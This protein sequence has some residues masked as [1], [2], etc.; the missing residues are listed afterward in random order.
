MG[1]LI[2]EYPGGVKFNVDHYK[3]VSEARGV[4]RV[5]SD[6]LV[7]KTIRMIDRPCHKETIL[8]IETVDVSGK[9]ITEVREAVTDK[10]IKSYPFINNRIVIDYKGPVNG[11]IIYQVTE[12]RKNF[13]IVE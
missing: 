7:G 2:I 10:M 8:H 11:D 5:D 3:R 1:D 12:F 9:G 13:E 6:K 4:E